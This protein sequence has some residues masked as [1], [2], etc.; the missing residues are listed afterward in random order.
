MRATHRALAAA[1]LGL[2]AILTLG[3]GDSAGPAA[4]TTGAI[5]ISVSTTSADIDVDP[6]GYALSIDGQ[7]GQAVAVSAILTIGALVPGTHLV[8]LD[9][10]ASNCSVQGPNPRTV[11]VF[12]GTAAWPVTFSVSCSAKDGGGGAWDY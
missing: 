12:P 11:Y 6:D 7:P 5:E 3:C 8:L 9:G 4:Q 1:F 2:A 10:L